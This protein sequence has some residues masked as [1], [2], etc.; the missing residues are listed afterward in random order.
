MALPR[1]KQS[2]KSFFD[3]FDSLSS[4]LLMLFI[5]LMVVVSI[6]MVSITEISYYSS[7]RK[8]LID[9]AEKLIKVQLPTLQEAM[10]EYNIDSIS[11]QLAAISALPFVSQVQLVGMGG[12]LVD[13]HGE[14]L[15]ER[16]EYFISHSL[17]YNSGEKPEQIGSVFLIINDKQIVQSVFDRLFR[18][19]LI[20]LVLTGSMV[21][22][23]IFF[24]RLIISNPLT[25]LRQAIDRSRNEYSNAPLIWKSHDEIADVVQSYNEM[26]KQQTESTNAL[27]RQTE[28]LRHAWQA[29]ED[30]R[31]VSERTR[32][33]LRVKVNEV[34]RFN[35]LAVG[36]ELRINELKERVNNLLIELGHTPEYSILSDEH[37][38]EDDKTLEGN[39]ERNQAGEMRSA[40]TKK[41]ELL[42]SHNDF[43][44][45]FI[46]NINTKAVEFIARRYFLSV[47]AT[48]NDGQVILNIDNLSLNKGKSGEHYRSI[49]SR[50]S[51][52]SSYKIITIGATEHHPECKIYQNSNGECDVLFDYIYDG[53]EIAKVSIGSFQFI[54]HIE[55]KALY[56]RVQKGEGIKFAESELMEF[57]TFLLV[58]C[59]TQIELLLSKIETISGEKNLRQQREAALTLAED[60]NIARRELSEYQLHLQR[61]IE[62]RTRNLEETTSILQLALSNMTDGIFM[63]DSKLTFKLTNPRFI[64]L[65]DIPEAMVSNGVSYHN[66]EEFMKKRGDI[67]VRLDNQVPQNEQPFIMDFLTSKHDTAMI[68]LANGSILGFQ[69]TVTSE[70]N[71]VAVVVDI[72][73]RRLAE[74]ALEES[75]ERMRMILDSI[76]EGILG[77]D[78]QGVIT[79]INPTVTMR[80][81]FEPDDIIGSSI[82]NFLLIPS[83]DGRQTFPVPEQEF[84][85]TLKFAMEVHVTD[86]SILCSDGSTFDIEYSCKPIYKE[87]SLVGCVFTFQDIS[88]R[89]RTQRELETKMVE[90]EQFSAVAIGRELKMIELKK[91]I[92]QLHE[93]LGDTPPYDLAA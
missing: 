36:R 16:P 3:N 26:Q 78:L 23:T 25:K 1:S 24:T 7:E 71:I 81:G 35:S 52:G 63:L 70:G 79:F 2:G 29:T 90:L 59:S 93:Q 48:T 75:E 82:R 83:R 34:E 28:E 80:L 47:N 32:E 92:N 46:A 56:Y 43:Y 11:R 42:L 73:T 77:L 39:S 66:V 8:R 85:D 6:L 91:E 22:G 57:I 65:L 84:E 74:I 27:Q 58:L 45:Y 17:F 14:G 68:R 87:G 37:I 53:V 19:V 12:E 50:L 64:A 5:P 33:E 38:G 49:L 31:R 88:E 15:P 54:E 30:A 20:L 9:D 89:R 41:S 10:W 40:T 67:L 76:A 69:Y 51:E 61:L 72:T 44:N 18:S 60:A 62:E 4:K 86:R 13:K 21:V 55:E